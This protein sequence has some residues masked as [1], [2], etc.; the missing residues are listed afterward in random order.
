MSVAQVEAHSTVSFDNALHHAAARALAKY[1]AEERR[2]KRG[3][4]IALSGGVVLLDDGT[5]LVQS[6]THEHVKYRVNGKCQCP[7]MHAPEGRCQHRWA[8]SLQKWSVRA[9]LDTEQ[10]APRYYA[11]YSKPDGTDVHGIATWTSRGW[12]FC[13]EDG[14][15][16]DFIA[17]QALSLGGNLN[18]AEQ[19]RQEEEAAGG[20]A[21]I[22]C[23]YG[24]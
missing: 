12:L 19:K 4:A 24:K 23:G 21:R 3:L 7:D 1:P 5:A 20:L 17:I 18:I 11:T 14:S 16:Y 8:K 2:I 22:V 10:P 13:S 9:M 6:Q 15:C